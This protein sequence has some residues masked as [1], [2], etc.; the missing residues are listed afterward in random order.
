VVGRLFPQHYIAISQREHLVGRFNAHFMQCLLVFVDEAMWAGDKQGEGTLKHLVT[1]TELMVEQKY[2][3]GFMVRNISRLIIAGNERWNVPAG[4]RARRW[5]VLDVANTHM[6]DRGYFRAIAH[7][8]MN[9]GDAALMHLLLT[10]DLNSVDVFTV[11]KTAALLEQKE[12]TMHAHERWWMECLQEGQL[13]FPDWTPGGK[14]A[15]ISNGWPT[16]VPK[17]Q[18]WDSYRLWVSEHNLRIRVWPGSQLHKWL[19]SLLPGSQEYRPPPP[20]RRRRVP[21]PGLEACREAFEQSVGQTIEWEDPENGEE[22]PY[23]TVAREQERPRP[24]AGK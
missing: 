6:Q 17:D 15:D 13:R 9:G 21:L 16:E 1:D 12:E 20:D 23:A 3:D 10:F 14:Q 7:E 5:C 8:M 19:R 24:R 4:L 11:P 22:D 2:K 18:L